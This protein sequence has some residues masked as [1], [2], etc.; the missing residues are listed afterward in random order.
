MRLEELPSGSSVF[1]DANIF[2][3]HFSGV[4]PECSRAL[5][6][7]ATS[8]LVGA[9]TAHIVLEVAHRMM[10]LEAV[11]KG[12]VARGDVAKKLAER[13]EAVSQLGEYRHNVQA[14]PEMGITVLPVSFAMWQSGTEYQQR[15]G[16]LTSDAVLLAACVDNH[17]RNLASGDKA[18][19]L[20][21]EIRL[22]A[23]SNAYN[24]GR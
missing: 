23:P 16:L 4:S 1:I 6:R 12:V 20:A 19:A 24:R 5:E 10:L 9:T 22:Y 2:I 13:P 8:E 21:K 3:Y 17:C 14:I 18:F 11:L 7:C 15:Y